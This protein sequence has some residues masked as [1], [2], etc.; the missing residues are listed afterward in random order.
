MKFYRIAHQTIMSGLV[1]RYREIKKY[2]NGIEISASRDGVGF[3]GVS[4]P[5]S[6][7]DVKDI[8][9]VLARADKL[10]D[11][12]RRNE[13]TRLTT[14]DIDRIP[15]SSE[16]ECVIQTHKAH[17]AGIDEILETREVEEHA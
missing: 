4:T 12:I 17:F 8:T 6:A 9:R 10:V 16:P 14:R 13:F 3:E 5:L 11:L 2:D 1:I 7:E 15:L